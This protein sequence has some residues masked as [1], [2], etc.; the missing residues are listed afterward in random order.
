VYVC[1]CKGLTGRDVLRLARP[2]RISE[3]ALIEDLGLNDRACCGRCARNIGEFVALAMR[4]PTTHQ[5]D[6]LP[7]STT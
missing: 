2:G 6:S 7:A 5:G 3:E 1:L 4:H